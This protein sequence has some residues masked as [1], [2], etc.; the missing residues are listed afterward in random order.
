MAERDTLVEAH[1]ITYE[2]LLDL[3]KLIK[4]I[5]EWFREHGYEEKDIQTNEIVTPTGKHIIREVLPYK[6]ISDYIKYEI[7][8][9]MNIRDVKDVEVEIKGRKTKKN[10]A[11]ITM[12]FDV[13]FVTDYEG[14]WGTNPIYYFLRTVFDKFVYK[15]PIERSKAGLMKDFNELRRDIKAYLNLM[16]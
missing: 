9:F 7:R 14:T 1:K 10:K 8:I 13:Y 2:G 15:G 16:T 12:M 3:R 4:T 6:K 11:N 5:D